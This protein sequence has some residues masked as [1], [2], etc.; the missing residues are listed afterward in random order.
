MLFLLLTPVVLVLLFILV[1]SWFR[2]GALADEM[3]ARAL[4]RRHEGNER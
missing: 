2:A 3:A 1:L 4:A